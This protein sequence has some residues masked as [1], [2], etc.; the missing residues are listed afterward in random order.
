M[1]QIIYFSSSILLILSFIILVIQVKQHLDIQIFQLISIG[2]LGFFLLFLSLFIAYSF[3]STNP[4]SFIS[5]KFLFLLVL[6]FGILCG[7]IAILFWFITIEILHFEEDINILGNIFLLRSSYIL[8]G[9]SMGLSIFDLSEKIT[10]SNY[11]LS[12]NHPLTV[13]FIFLS[14]G[15][16]FIFQISLLLHRIKQFQFTNYRKIFNLNTAE[17]LI[18]IYFVSFSIAI[19]LFTVENFLGYTSYSLL[20]ISLGLL[21]QISITLLLIKIPIILLTTEEPSLIMLLTDSGTSIYARNFTNEI[22]TP[23]QLIAGYLS[24][25]DSLGSNIISSSGIVSSVKFEDKY[26]FLIT[27]LSKEDFSIRFCYIYKGMSYYA[28]TRLTKFSQEI[29]KNTQVWN[30]IV[31]SQKEGKKMQKNEHLELHIKKNFQKII[32]D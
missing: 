32:Y 8:L 28:S 17:L 12:F 23:E 18:I 29:L 14:Y 4:I 5:R 26:T 10:N 24:A 11:E 21:S 31:L 1:L 9:I 13:L 7:F 6:R 16:F 3:N 2:Q 25:L 30:E 15:L 20:W 27:N 19:I 22:T